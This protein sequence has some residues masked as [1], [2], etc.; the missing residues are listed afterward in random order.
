MS[1]NRKRN[2]NN[3]YTKDYQQHNKKG[4]KRPWKKESHQNKEVGYFVQL[5]ED[6]SFENML[7]RFLKK[8]LKFKVV[9]E[10]RKRKRYVKPSVIKRKAK[11]DAEFRM[12]HNLPRIP[13]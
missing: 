8:E 5:R 2:N 6:E 11:Q 7:K 9:E 12:K 10:A 13:K 1:I 3:S 4:K